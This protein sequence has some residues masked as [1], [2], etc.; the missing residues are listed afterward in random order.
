MAAWQNEQP[1]DLLVCD[2]NKHPK[3][4]LQWAE[5]LFPFLRTGGLFIM[6]LKFFGKA[7][8]KTEALK[9]LSPILDE[10]FDDVD[11]IWLL[12]NTVHERTLVARKR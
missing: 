12:A 7:R 6:T 9:L 8:D 3:E 5:P 2:I 1:S 4:V 10:H 11:C